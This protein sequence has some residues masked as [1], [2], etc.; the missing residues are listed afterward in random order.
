MTRS[1]LRMRLHVAGAAAAGLAVRLYFILR[2]PFRASGDTFF[3][4]QLARNWLDHGV[5]G[6]YIAGRRSTRCSA[7]RSLR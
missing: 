3:Y 1:I 7:G 4:E 2:F 6:L 5:Y